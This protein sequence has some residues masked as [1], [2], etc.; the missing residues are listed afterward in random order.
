MDIKGLL[1]IGRWSG[2]LVEKTIKWNGHTFEIFVKKDLSPADFEF[3]YTTEKG[4]EDSHM[5]RRVAR[6]VFMDGEPI[7]YDV[8]KSLKSSL[9]AAMCGAINDVQDKIGE[10]K[11]T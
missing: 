7:G 1:E 6:C 3:I 4:K 11:K 10:A 2:D 9:L 8:A 5:A